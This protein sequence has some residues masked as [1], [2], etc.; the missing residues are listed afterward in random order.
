MS[1]D[2][3]HIF[4]FEDCSDKS[5]DSAFGIYPDKNSSSSSTFDICVEGSSPI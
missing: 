3:D 4:G 2:D 1:S 5:H